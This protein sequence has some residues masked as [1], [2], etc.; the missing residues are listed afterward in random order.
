[1]LVDEPSKPFKRTFYDSGRISCLSTICRS[2]YVN[3]NILTK[4]SSSQ[5]V[6]GLLTHSVTD[7][8]LNND[9]FSDDILFKSIYLSF[10]SDLDG[11]KVKNTRIRQ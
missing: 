3:K 11:N 10:L 7:T 4:S 9:Y 6:Q 2:Y 8:S 1:M 5:I